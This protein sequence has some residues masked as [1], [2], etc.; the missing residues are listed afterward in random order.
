MAAK[1]FQYDEN[2]VP[3]PEYRVRPVTRFVVTRFCHPYRAADGSHYD[4]GGSEIIGEFDS[5]IRAGDVAEAMAKAD[6]HPRASVYR[7]K[8][9]GIGGTSLG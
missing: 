6:S 7:Q 1:D 4:A 8:R 2:S 3:G 5:E 9:A